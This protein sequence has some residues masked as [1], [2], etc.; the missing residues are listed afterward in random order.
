M[1]PEQPELSS[2]QAAIT[3]PPR[4]LLDPYDQEY[5]ETSLDA[6]FAE[7]PSPILAIDGRGTRARLRVRMPLSQVVSRSIAVSPGSRNLALMRRCGPKEP[8][9]PTSIT[10]HGYREVIHHVVSRADDLPAQQDSTSLGI[11]RPVLDEL[12]QAFYDIAID[13]DTPAR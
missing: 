2:R 11:G 12:K 3:N 8:G 7:P 1:P 5:R 10:A 6:I 9:S 13:L 4:H